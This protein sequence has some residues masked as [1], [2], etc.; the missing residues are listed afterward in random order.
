MHSCQPAPEYAKEFG[1]VMRKVFEH[2]AVMDFDDKT[3]MSLVR[4][5]GIWQERQIFDKKVPHTSPLVLS[6]RS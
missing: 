5:I 2:L 3:I 4:L 1:M 6:A